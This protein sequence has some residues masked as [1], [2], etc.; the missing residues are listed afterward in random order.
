MTHRR[1][2]RSVF[3]AALGLE[4][5]VRLKSARA[6][7]KAAAPRWLTDASPAEA[8]DNPDLLLMRIEALRLDPTQVKASMP[9]EFRALARVCNYCQDKVR[10][11]RDLVHEA[12]GKAVDWEHY[13]PNAFRLRA[14]GLLGLSDQGADPPAR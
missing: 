4:K 7:P 11:E 13:C 8:C 6:A 5:Q 1:D 14:T 10:C 12:A 2:W 9:T 3:E